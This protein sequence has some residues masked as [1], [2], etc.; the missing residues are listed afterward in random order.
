MPTAIRRISRPIT[1]GLG[2]SRDPAASSRLS[3]PGHWTD[4]V[5]FGPDGETVRQVGLLYSIRVKGQ[6]LI[7][8]DV[9]SIT[10]FPDGSVVIKGPHDVF[11]NGL[12]PLICPLFE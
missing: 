11:D 8:H 3:D 10:F 7:L 2:R 1:A 6:G 5:T 9:G 12:E 4:F